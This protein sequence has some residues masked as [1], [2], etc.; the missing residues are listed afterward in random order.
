ML[1]IRGGRCGTLPMWPPPARPSKTR[2]KAKR[3]P[4]RGATLPN[5]RSIS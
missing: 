3:K 5:K 4:R 2:P 1:K